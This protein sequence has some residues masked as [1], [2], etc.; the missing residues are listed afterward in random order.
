MKSEKVI[1]ILISLLIL[2]FYCPNEVKAVNSDKK[3]I[4]A[5]IDSKI[6]ILHEDMSNRCIKGRSFLLND[7]NMTGHGTAVAGASLKYADTTAKKLWNKKSNVYIL[8]VEIN[9]L[10]IQNDNGKQIGEAIKYAVDSG[11]DIINMSFS[12]ASPNMYIYENIRYGLEKGVIFVSA[13]GNSGYNIYSYPAAYDGVISVGSYCAIDVGIKR[14][15]FSNSNDDVDILMEGEKIML[16]NE[17]SGYSERSGTSFSAGA[18]SGVLGAFIDSYPEIKP[19]HIVYALYD[20]A[21]LSLLKDEN[22]CGYGIPDINKA[23]EYLDEMRKI[24]KSPL[25]NKSFS[26]SES[27]LKE[28]KSI[29]S[30]MVSAGRSHLAFL[31]EGKVKIEGNKSSNRAGVLNFKDAVKVYAGNDNTAVISSKNMAMASGYNVFNKNIFKGWTNINELIL[32][33]NFTAGLTNDGHVLV[34]DYIK[35]TGKQNWNDIKQISA[36]V[37]HLAAVT[38]SGKVLTAGYNIYGQM[39]TSKWEN[40]IMTASSTRN[41]VGLDIYGHVYCTGDNLYGQCNL[42]DWKDIKSVDAGDGFVIG[43]KKDGTVTA[44]GRNI[45]NVCQVSDLKDIVYIDCADTYFVAVDNKNNCF[46]KGKMK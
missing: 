14:S 11:A 6:N 45:Y 15:I 23:R 3:T 1:I 17:D 18:F 10:D 2:V 28:I 19:E 24:G 36:G 12:S 43:L 4:I 32:S 30:F 5:V 9:V 42:E 8:P 21:S 25:S 26:D 16:P 40:I 29:R 33:P 35:Y 46:I 22:G 27:F 31:E 34:T 44:K 39:N 20:T 38:S 41:T 7:S 13:A 37:H